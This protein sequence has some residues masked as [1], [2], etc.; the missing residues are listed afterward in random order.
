MTGSSHTSTKTKIHNWANLGWKKQMMHKNT[1]T[2]PIIPT[3]PTCQKTTEPEHHFYNCN[4]SRMGVELKQLHKS[5]MKLNTSP[6][7]ISYIPC[8]LQFKINPLIKTPQTKYEIAINKAIKT[9][10]KLVSRQV[11]KGHLY[12]QWIAPQKIYMTTLPSQTPLA[13]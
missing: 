9:Q 13:P 3:C 5:L 4:T 6:H 7:I 11:Q 12:H 2:I 8:S 10:N 1:D